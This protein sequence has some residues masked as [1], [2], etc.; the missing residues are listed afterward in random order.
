MA[1][2]N[3]KDGKKDENAKPTI[4]D[5]FRKKLRDR[6]QI[7]AT[8]TE[9]LKSTNSR[10][11]S[12]AVKAAFK[13]RDHS[14]IKQNVLA[15]IKSDKSKKVLRTL[16]DKIT[17]RDLYKKVKASKVMKKFG[18]KDAPADAPT[19]ETKTT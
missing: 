19:T 13:L 5:E 10:I 9:G 4:V 8:V 3:E 17:R 15:L 16:S 1:K 2:P 6:D 14:F 12:L 18:K 7:K 11:R